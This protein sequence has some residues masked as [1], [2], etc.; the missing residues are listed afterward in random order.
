MENV[1]YELRIRAI[2]AVRRL[3]YELDTEP[4]IWVQVDDQCEVP[5]AYVDQNGFIVFDIHEEAVNRFEIRDGWMSF[6]SR[7]GENNAIEEIAVPL[8]RIAKAAV[9]SDLGDGVHFRTSPTTPEM[10]AAFRGEKSIEAP[11]Q[12]GGAARRPLRVK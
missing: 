5:R 4:Y 8:T 3:A 10:V 7:F 11:S 6:Q 12:L 1:Q 2:E 9:E